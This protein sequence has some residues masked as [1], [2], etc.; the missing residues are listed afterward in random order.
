[1]LPVP[2]PLIML[3]RAQHAPCLGNAAVAW[4]L[5][6][7]GGQHVQVMVELLLHLHLHPQHILGVAA[8]GPK[9][10][11]QSSGPKTVRHARELSATT[12]SPLKNVS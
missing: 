9:T 10:C 5:N 11:H 2:L 4:R 12:S 7:H 1:L 8:A 3:L 6:Q